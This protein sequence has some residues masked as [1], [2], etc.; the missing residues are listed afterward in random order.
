MLARTLAK[1]GVRPLG[2]AFGWT[3]YREGPDG[4]LKR[5]NLLGQLMSNTQQ[6]GLV[7]RGEYLHLSR[8]VGAMVGTLAG[9]YAG[10]PRRRVMLDLML[11]LNTFPARVL[12]DALRGGTPGL[13]GLIGV[14]DAALARR[15]AADEP[16]ATATIGPSRPGSGSPI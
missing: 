4:W 9:L 11:A 3:L 2:L 15:D 16:E 12:Q 14:L 10:V 8:S 1:K 7:L 5:A 13:R 6:L